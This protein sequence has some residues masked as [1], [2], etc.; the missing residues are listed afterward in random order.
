M[1]YSQNLTNKGDMAISETALPLI[2]DFSLFF[3][4]ISILSD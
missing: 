2:S 4:S 3:V 1:S